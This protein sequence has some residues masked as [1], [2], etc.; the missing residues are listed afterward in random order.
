LAR[1]RRRSVRGRVAAVCAAAAGV[2]ALAACGDEGDTSPG[3][4][5]GTGLPQGSEPVELDPADVD[6]RYWPMEP[7]T[8]W[9]YREVDEEGKEVIV[10]VTV[11]SETKKIT[12]GITARVVRDTV[13]EDS[14][15]IEDTLDWYAQDA[16]GN[17]W[18]LGETRPSS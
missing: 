6:N 15:L 11:S 3:A 13:T 18:Y 10:V 7:G 1:P 12:N 8:R 16:D 14:E 4:A 2:L 17:V 5:T 9:T